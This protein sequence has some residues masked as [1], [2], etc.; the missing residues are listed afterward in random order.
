M[1]GCE[2]PAVHADHVLLG[3]VEHARDFRHLLR[4]RSPSPI[5]CI[6]PFSLRRLKNSFSGRGGAIFTSDQLCG[7][8]PGSRLIHHMA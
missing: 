7:W 6:W 2:E 1:V 3:H 4:L 8:V 5:A